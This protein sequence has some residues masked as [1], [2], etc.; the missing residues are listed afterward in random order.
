ME[1]NKNKKHECA[2]C[3][4]KYPQTREYWHWL[5]ES[6]D[7]LN[8]TCIQ[9][10]RKSAREWRNR[11]KDEINRKA[12]EYYS[13][14]VNRLI[15]DEQNYRSYLKN[16]EHH[17]EQ[18]RIRNRIFTENYR[19]TPYQEKEYMRQV[20]TFETTGQ[21]NKRGEHKK[22]C[23]CCH[24]VYGLSDFHKSITNPDGHSYE[25]RYCKAEKDQGRSR[26]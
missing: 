20:H 4:K 26:H 2:Q 21:K 8:S 7:T 3:R 23:C 5:K 10:V 9:C 1:N 25:C 12:R 22:E 15:R 19:Q 18:N 6:D 16:R 17:E 14:P 11:K 13:D 24:Q